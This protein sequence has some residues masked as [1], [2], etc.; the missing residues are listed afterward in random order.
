MEKLSIFVTVVFCAYCFAMND[1]HLLWKRH[2]KFIQKYPCRTPQPKV[3]T[4][5]ELVDVG[6]LSNLGFDVS[7]QLSAI[8]RDLDLDCVLSK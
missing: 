4:L 2:E 6:S 7:I 1:K 8:L 3:V 5:E